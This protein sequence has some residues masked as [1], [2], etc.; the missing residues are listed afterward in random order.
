M[1]I[2]LQGKE[3]KKRAVEVPFFIKKTKQNKKL[4]QALS[5]F[6]RE[7]QISVSVCTFI[8]MLFR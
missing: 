7:S 5:W 8:N 3:K 6:V 1:L 2:T 4:S